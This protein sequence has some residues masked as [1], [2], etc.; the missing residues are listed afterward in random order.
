MRCYRHTVEVNRQDHIS[1][2]MY[3]VKRQ[4][5]WE[6]TAMDTI[7]QRKLQLFGHICRMPDNQLLKSLVFGMVE[8]ERE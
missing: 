7:R 5:Q 8:E 4:V 2:Y 6:W 3:E 1:N